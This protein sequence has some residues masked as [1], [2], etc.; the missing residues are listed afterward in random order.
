ML[1]PRGF[2]VACGWGGEPEQVQQG[3]ISW[4]RDA[5]EEA[6]AV[7]SRRLYWIHCKEKK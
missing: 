2:E 5:K 6:S 3:F 4:T 7:E 1:P